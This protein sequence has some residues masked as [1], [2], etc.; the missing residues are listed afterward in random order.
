MHK[1]IC[2]YNFPLQQWEAGPSTSPPFANLCINK[3]T[4]V[5]TF[6]TDNQI[7]PN[8]QHTEFYTTPDNN[9]Y[10]KESKKEQTHV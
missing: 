10:E 2:I 9:L 6:E 1:Y 3:Y 4:Y 7:R 8:E 5:Y